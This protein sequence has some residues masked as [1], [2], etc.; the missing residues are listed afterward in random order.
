[1]NIVWLPKAITT[2][3]AQLDYIAK[4]N[5][6]AAIEYGDRLENQVDQL[7]THPD[8]G[9]AGRKQGT[10]E[11]VISRTSF[12]VIYRVKS[13]AKC[14]EILRVLHSSQQWPR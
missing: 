3:D 4:E 7:T 10:R 13:K 12:I 5:V 2:R 9:R 11:L 1:M 14:I 8:L 6:A